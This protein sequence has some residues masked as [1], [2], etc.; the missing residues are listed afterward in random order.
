M[1]RWIVSSSLKARG[2][3]LVAAIV[4]IVL[5]VSQIR[6]APKDVLPEFGQPT[7]HV[8]TEALGLS[9]TEVEQLI[10]TPLEQDLLNGTP[11]LDAIRS[12]SV[13]GM[14]S[15]DM[16]F[17]AGTDLA[18]ARLVVNERLTQAHALPNVSK[19]PQMLQPLSST[20]RVLMIGLSSKQLSLIDMSVLARWT[21]RPR[22]MGVPGVANVAIWGQRERQL[23]VQVDPAQLQAAG[24][25][26]EQVITTT[27][28]S[29][30]WSP[31]GRLEA[32]TPGTGGF[33]DGPTQRLGI[34]HESPIQNPDDLARVVL[35]DQ[36]T[37][38]GGETTP[39]KTLGDVATV[40]ADHPPLIGDAV[41]SDGPG[42]LLVVEKFPDA[43]V[44]DVT[45]GVEKALG[46]LAPGLAG[47]QID[48]A[49][50]RPATYVDTAANNVVKALLV[51]V[52]LVVLLLL[53]VLWD[54]RRALISGITIMLSLAAAGLV[55]LLR[56][57]TIN[58]MILAGIVLAVVVLVDDSV[59][60]SDHTRR[61][62][63]KHDTAPP[64]VAERIIAESTMEIRSPLLFGTVA[65]LLALL[66]I[67][68]LTGESGAFLPTVALSY[69]TAVL[70][71]LLVALTVT[72]ALS[73]TLLTKPAADQDAPVVRLLTRGHDRL[74][75]RIIRSPRVAYG[76]LA[77]LVLGS[78]ALLPGVD[79]GD[80]LV[81]KFADNNLLI[82]W[83]AT[84]GT[85]IT[86][87][88]RIT[89]R[90]ARELRS[91]P[92]V[93]DVG[94]HVGRAIMADQ[95]VTPSSGEIWVNIDPAAPYEKTVSAVESAIALYPGLAS[96]V[97]TYPQDRVTE[98]LHPKSHDLTVRVFGFEYSV[99]RTK[100]AEVQKL[101]EGVPGVKSP[102]VDSPA[103]VPALQVKVDL[104]AAKKYG[105]KPGDVRRAAT[106]LLS[107]IEVGAL[108]EEQK[109]FEVVVLGSPATRQN[110]S[111]VR[112]LL[113][114]TPEGAH[115]RLG[116]V[117]DVQV[118]AADDVIQ[119]DAVTRTLDVT[120]DVSGRD[121]SAVAKDIRQRLQD[122]DMPYE[123]HA[124]V[125]S[126]YVEQ[127]EARQRF[128]AVV[129]AA[130]IG[131]FLV[132]QASVGS[133][134]LG[135]LA[136]LMLPASLAGCVV[137][138]LVT[139]GE[140]TIGSL[141]AFFAVLGISAR[142]TVL[143]ISRYQQLER[144]SPDAPKADVIVR[145][146]RERFV[147]VVLT[148]AGATVALLPMLLFSRTAGYELAHP[149]TVTVVLGLVSSAVV[150]L[151][152][153][154][155][156]YVRFA[157]GHEHGLAAE[158]VDVTERWAP[159]APASTTVTD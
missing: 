138:V 10:T 117:A 51:G 55:L 109:V 140:I 90:A 155:A 82:H 100:A 98:L 28:N 38:A 73:R 99:L 77:V 86:E 93:R 23:Q 132:L 14:S 146:T 72:P 85:S 122:V 105:I 136:F 45:D 115:V 78:L 110:L 66:P 32:N 153:L 74:I 128:I 8:Q 7:V 119:H 13:A 152:V 36:A 5:G 157:G 68:V 151:L 75:P 60:D 3:V 116:D 64:D 16:I 1:T 156:L 114:D 20:S 9:A 80:T 134:R 6:D 26:L 12:K 17:E 52:A 145:A 2:A 97:M 40:V 61:R 59:I 133:W 11:F 42:L 56:G 62:P 159:S 79:H 22:L 139:G 144:Q 141:A 46:E 154:P 84:P 101:L 148:L 70:A 124:E 49:V 15:I 113:I 31:L 102:R 67:L 50:F 33:V 91:I 18:R 137:G 142:H 58:A 35:D 120:A 94:A 44:V 25:S 43:N 107:G 111:T 65:L 135:A 106:S 127:N 83:E 39:A 118:A 147:P 29:L 103:A 4:V 95:V 71:S 41:V 54:W 87:M 143:L 104:D 158:P 53:L 129:I 69:A 76:V 108:F 125:V 96:S 21:V 48:S 123:Y 81:P 47:V 88:D 92:G 130:A 27:G 89:A 131:I 37:P 150:S 149:L 63:R 112:D 121:V 24:V 34:F 57:E 19:P 30:W 126:D